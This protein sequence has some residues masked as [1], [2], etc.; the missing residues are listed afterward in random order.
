MNEAKLVYTHINRI[1]KEL[2]E[3][4]LC[5]DQN[6]PRIA[7][8]PE[9]AVRVNIGDL[10]N[11]IF[12]KNVPYKDVYYAML[13]K[14]EYNMKMIDGALILMDYTFKDDVIYKHRLSFF[15][16]PD[17]LEFQQNQELYMEDDLYLDILNKQIV[18][19]PFRFDFDKSVGKEVEHPQSHFTIGQYENCRI[20]VSAAVS[21]GV[22]VKFIIR[23]FYHTAFDK[24]VGKLSDLKIEFDRTITE[25]EMKLVHIEV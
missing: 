3:T 2:I 13:R 6:F 21:P 4:G 10:E 14:R 5:D 25:N 19:V 22:F 16:S 15:P 7:R 11:N 9:K 24:Y 18:T 23:N 1:T 8:E 20:P 17:L 12:L